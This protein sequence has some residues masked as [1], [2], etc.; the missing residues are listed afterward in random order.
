MSKPTASAAASEDFRG[1]QLPAG[2]PTVLE[3]IVTARRGHLEGIRRRIAHVD[4]EAL[5]R[6]TRSL[7]DSLQ[8]GRGGARFIM[9]CKSASP[10]LGVIRSDYHPGDIARLYSRY[11][12]GISVLCEPERFGGD[13]DH[14]QTVA[15]ST[16]LPVLCK[17]FIIDPV[18]IHAARYF[19]ADAVLLMLSILDDD[20][21]ARLAAEAERFGLDVL[22]EVI[23]AEEVDRALRLGARIVGCNNRNLHDLS[24]DLGR[25][26]ELAPLIPD[27]VVYLSE[28]GIRTHAD[29]VALSGA[30]N[31]FLV[32]SQLTGSADIDAAIRSLVY[33]PVKVCGLRSAAAA[34]AARAAGATYGGLIFE[35]ASPRAVDAEAAAEIIAGEPNLGY[36]AVSR[37]TSG[38]DELLQPGIVAVQVHA[39]TGTVEEELALV[40]RIRTELPEGVELW[41]AVS[42]T[43]PQGPAVAEALVVHGVDRLVL[44]SGVGGTGEAFDWSRIPAAVKEHS[45]LAGGITPETVQDALATG[46]AGVD[47]NSGVEYPGEPAHTKDS[48]ALARALDKV[49]TFHVK[50]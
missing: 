23:D 49:R 6:S 7:Y 36:V 25:T 45:L 32:G 16:H 30:V 3:G 40:D 35:P 34:Q 19:G 21:Y 42:M 43:T 22:T 38:Y 8:Q 12:A 5:P 48:A 33:G 44:D 13:Y 41:R 11:A 46:C 9:E 20:T 17:D 10:S 26:L 24:I 15:L 4:V 50:H 28:S 2:V 18:Q 29:V 37:Q 14:L 47:L 1:V 31:G 39:P 27:D